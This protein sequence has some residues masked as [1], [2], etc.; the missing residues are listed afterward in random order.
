MGSFLK[1][2]PTVVLIWESVTVDITATDNK[3]KTAKTVLNFITLYLKKIT[4]RNY[5]PGGVCSITEKS[6]TLYAY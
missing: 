2:F 6:R 5:I 1:E 3:N 4:P